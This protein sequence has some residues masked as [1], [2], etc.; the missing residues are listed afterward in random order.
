MC[1]SVGVCVWEADQLSSSLLACTCVFVAGYHR[2]RCYA[3]L[4]R[5]QEAYDELCTL[6]LD[7]PDLVDHKDDIVQ[8]RG[9][10]HLQL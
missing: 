7:H 4:K 3:A 8:V 10:P 6:D 1:I 9:P 5:Y 2:A